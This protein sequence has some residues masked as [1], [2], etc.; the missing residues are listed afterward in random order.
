M[1]FR[2]AYDES[3]ANGKSDTENVKWIGGVD[4]ENKTGEM[5]YASRL[6]EGLLFEKILELGNTKAMFF[7]HDH[8]NNFVLDYQGVLFSYGYSIDYAAYNGDLENKGLQR[9]CTVLTLTPDGEF[10]AENIVHENY[11]QDKYQP[12]YEKEEVEMTPLYD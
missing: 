1:L 2:S 11:Y 7:G 12:L 9:G 4:G 5:V 3:V 6:D 10:V 8:L